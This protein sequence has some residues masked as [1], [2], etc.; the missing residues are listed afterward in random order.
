MDFSHIGVYRNDP[1]GLGIFALDVNGNYAYDGG[2]KF[3]FFGLAGDQPVAGD[4]DGTGVVRLGTF[5]CPAVGQPGTCTWSFDMNNSGTFDAGDVQFQFGLPGD[6]PVVGD[7]TGNGVTKIGVFRCPAAGTCTFILDQQNHRAADSTNVF[8]SFGLAGDLPVV[9]N[10]SNSSKVDQVGIFR[11]AA[12]A[13]ASTGIPGVPAGQCGWVVD[14]FGLGS[15]SWIRQDVAVCFWA[16][17]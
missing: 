9:N 13:T 12:S 11:C 3:R 7:W 10:W 1:S 14:S 6:I 4:W 15:F 17:R 16:A 8:L 5:R 2:D